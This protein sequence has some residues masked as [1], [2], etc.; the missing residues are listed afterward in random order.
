MTRM[1]ARPSLDPRQQAAAALARAQ[2]NLEQAVA[3]LDK[4][5]AV[6]ARSIGLATHA[7]GNFLTVCDGVIELLRKALADQ[8]DGDVAMY[9]D[10]LSH[11]TNLM[12]HT[13]SQLMNSS[14]GAE[15]PLRLSD[16]DLAR[17]VERACAYY[18]RAAAQKGIDILFEA[19]AELPA[20]RGDR[21]LVAAVV[22]N[23][24]SNAVKYSPPGR[25]IWVRVERQGGGVACA[26]RDEGPGLGPEQRARLFV[27]GERL[28]HV[29][30][31]GEPSS[32]YGL[33]I[34][35][36]FMEQMHGEIRC[37]SAPQQG[38]TF[39]FW[40]PADPPSSPS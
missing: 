5:P 22:D 4:L 9:L 18:R 15:R 29:P 35:K 30:T 24:L 11:I 34:A 26:V 14:A 19:G 20:A 8:P 17:L 38:A 6:D 27:A 28:G 21:V 36:R 13:V 7:L 39:S 16:V 32:G 33:A 31:A 23:L 12:A 37:T 25:R 1:S 40:L 3:E 10:A 2:A